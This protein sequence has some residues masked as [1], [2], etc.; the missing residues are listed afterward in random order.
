MMVGTK[1]VNTYDYEI[2]DSWAIFTSIYCCWWQE[3]ANC[4]FNIHSLEL[5]LELQ[6]KYNRSFL[7]SLNTK[8]LFA[9]IKKDIDFLFLLQVTLWFIP[10]SSLKLHLLYSLA[11]F[12]NLSPMI[13]TVPQWSVQLQTQQLVSRQTNKISFCSISRALR[14]ILKVMSTPMVDLRLK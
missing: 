6:K 11:T 5:L 3:N 8:L 14:E 12:T 13:G 2:F 4:S 7:L 9:V 1:L 10:K